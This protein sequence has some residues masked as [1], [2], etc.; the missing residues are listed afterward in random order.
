MRRALLLAV[1]TAAGCGLPGAPVKG[2]PCM[3][4][5]ESECMT[6][7]SLGVCDTVAGKW[8]ERACVGRC[9][10]AQTPRCEV[11]PPK[12]GEACPI[13]FEGGAACATATQRLICR[14]GAW[15][16]PVECANCRT[17]NGFIRCG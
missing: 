8:F 14:S 9:S 5:D 7:T 3:Q 10:N 4:G 17:E 11:M 16:E 15:G 13:S 2:Q 12:A 6:T 1:I